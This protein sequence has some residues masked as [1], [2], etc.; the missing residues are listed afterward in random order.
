MLF[1]HFERILPL[2][3]LRFAVTTSA[4]P[5]K[6]DDGCTAANDAMC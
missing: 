2:G 4:K 6:P 5:Q 1:A 3:R